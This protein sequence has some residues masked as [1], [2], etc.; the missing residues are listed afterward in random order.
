M[1]GGRRGSAAAHY[2]HERSV[3]R[4]RGAGQGRQ[5]SAQARTQSYGSRTSLTPPPPPPP[6]YTRRLCSW[7]IPDSEPTA[8]APSE[9]HTPSTAVRSDKRP[10]GERQTRSYPMPDD[11]Y[12]RPPLGHPT[13]TPSCSP[14]PLGPST[15]CQWTRIRG[16]PRCRAC[17]TR[18]FINCS[19]TIRPS[20]RP[21]APT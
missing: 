20:I 6:P 19:Y 4:F 10:G 15:L 7:W 12:M 18:T 8:L 17:D 21:T 2:V 14:P 11:T 16:K 13:A 3:S 9:E 1:G 5:Q